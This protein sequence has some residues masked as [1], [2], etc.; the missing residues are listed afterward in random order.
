MTSKLLIL[1]TVVGIVSYG[2]SSVDAP[3]VEQGNVSLRFVRGEA[4]NPVI[5]DGKGQT[6]LELAL[7]IA[8]SILVD[9]Y[10]PGG[11]T[12]ETGKGVGIP[13]GTDTVSLDLTV[14]AE[15][16]KRVAVRLFAGGALLYFGVD[17]DVDVVPNKNTSVSIQAVPF[18]IGTISAAPVSNPPGLWGGEPFSMWWPPVQGA[19]SYHVEGSLL[20]DFSLI[21]WDTTATD[22]LLAGMLPAGEYYFRVTARNVY[23]ESEWS[24]TQI[25]I[26][27]APQ[28][29][30]ISP[31]E[32]LRGFA[33]D[34]E[35]YGSD[36]HHYSTQVSVF[37]QTCTIN[38]ASPTRLQVTVTPAARAFSDFVTV[39][40]SPGG[41]DY[42]GV[43]ADLLK[44][45]AIAYVMADLSSG[46]LGTAAYYEALIESYGADI[47]DSAVFVMP[48]TMIGG[49]FFDDLSIFDVIVVGHD[50]GSDE[51]DW[52]GGGVQ[53]AVRSAMIQSSGAAVLGIGTGGAAYFQTIGLNIGIKSC[54]WD[55]GD[56]IWVVNSAA[57]IFSNPNAI[58]VPPSRLLDLYDAVVGPVRIGAVSPPNGVT[59]FGAW[60]PL[61]TEYSLCDEPALGAGLDRNSN[62]LW[63]FE[64]DP[65]DLT[66]L[67]FA[68]F[69]NA[70][71]YVFD[72]GTK[73]VV[74]P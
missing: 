72:D 68:V 66:P 21:A 45:R 13:G 29:T 3:E 34:F 53:G 44:I 12:R 30:G 60:G 7:P 31:T 41:T 18:T 59:R 63:G 58:V 62:L 64:G 25:H 49:G 61:S 23:A 67:G 19:T 39:S 26:G 28:V 42:S 1:I 55:V 48:Y 15:N 73:D 43:S 69:Q 22:T 14:I 51:T 8:D 20:S 11:G 4:E 24:T 47:R 57:A 27:G 40:N 56:G 52:G 16:D 36:L 2:C 32:V 38:G 5:K 71:V 6:P 50:T 33:Q 10:P 54:T 70:V 46:D 74:G 37:G 65:D 35:V 17:E 9:V